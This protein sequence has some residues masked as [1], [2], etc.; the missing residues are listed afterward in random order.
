M[1]TMQNRPS[2]V[3]L[4]SGFGAFNIVRNLK[5]DYDITVISPRNH[6]LFTPLLPSTTVG[7]I[8]FRS[9]IEPVRT[10]KENASFYY[11]HCTRID[12][13]KNIIHCKNALDGN[14]CSLPLDLLIIG[15]GAV[16]NTFGIKGVDQYA[17]PLKE[18]ADARAI[19]QR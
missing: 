6:F 15:V 18:L 2:L 1:D 4:G 3:I 14:E 16:S 19:R 9:I 10:A 17:M 5:D 8:E 7:T 12:T 13:E 11:A